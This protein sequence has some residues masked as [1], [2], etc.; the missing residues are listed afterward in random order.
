MTPVVT[1][2]NFIKDVNYIHDKLMSSCYQLKS[3]CMVKL[4]WN[5]LSK[6]VP[7]TPWRY[8]PAASLIRVWPQQVT[9]SSLMRNLLDSVK[10]SDLVKVVKTGRK[11]A[12]QTEDLVLNNC[13]QR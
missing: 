5:I 12:M 11:T 3:I 1:L 10:L 4:F 6:C 8:A 13:S 2:Y 7:G 9:H